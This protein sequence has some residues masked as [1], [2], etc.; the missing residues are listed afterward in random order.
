MKK[1]HKIDENW[2]TPA[3]LARELS[4]STEVI[5]N[6]IA[7]GRISFIELPSAKYRRHLVDRRT[8]PEVRKSGR[9]KK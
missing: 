7:R 8:A 6:W 1:T 5:T 2:V 3:A 4:T 9:P